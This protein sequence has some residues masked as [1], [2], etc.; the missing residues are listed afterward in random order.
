MS[1]CMTGSNEKILFRSS[2]RL[3]ITVAHSIFEKLVERSIH[4]GRSV[5]NLAAFL[6]ES[7]L[8]QHRY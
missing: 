1:V 7:S 4:E 5:S 8:E 6:I 3:T 2:R